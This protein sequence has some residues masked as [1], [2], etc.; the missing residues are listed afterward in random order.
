MTY[1]FKLARRLARF[2]ALLPVAVTVAFAGCDGTDRLAG[3][4]EEPAH[5][6]VAEPLATPVAPSFSSVFRGG[7][8]FGVAQLPKALYGS[9]Y[10]GSLA[11][12]YPEYVLSYLE[13]ARHSGTR[14]ILSF[15]GSETKYR[16]GDLSFSMSKWKQR[17]DR[18]R[19]IDFS[20]YI[21]DG[22][23]VGHYLIDEPH[24]PANWGGRTI[25][26]A[27][28][29]EM[30]K[31]SKQIWPTLPT[32]VRSWPAYLK[33]FDYKYLDAAWAQYSE[34]KGPASGFITENVRDAKAAGL[35]LIVGLNLLDGG[36][37]TSGLPGPTSGKYSM[38]ASQLESWGTALLSDPY[39]C[40]FISW[41][42]DAKYMGR[43]D[44]QSA[45]T[46]L[47]QQASVHAGSSCAVR[48]GAA[49]PPGATEPTDTAPPIEPPPVTLPSVTP[50]IALKVTGRIER[51]VQY[52]TLT[53]SG[54][55]GSSVDVYR[56]GAMKT[57]TRNDGRYVNSRRRRG[58]ATYA[59]KV[60]E[61]RRS[62][63]SKV[64][65]VTVK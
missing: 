20:S 64:V 6:S 29:E 63:C 4:A 26:P 44:I 19:G 50:A 58:A 37:R 1:T 52:M 11:N 46:R 18:F 5:G 45:V 40:A 13:A 34:R 54:A 22:T 12:F 33:G 16:N 38:S 10:N 2:R 43:S 60:C 56:D 27:T 21:E 49:S 8:P 23:L 57:N 35:A 17:V 51:G 15:S 9:I 42:F 65:R 41:K 24:D 48:S 32:I 39:P 31:Y 30:A 28:L 3:I 55:K 25:A 7:I 14:V 53:W 59:Y 47:S 62:T 36:T 61:T